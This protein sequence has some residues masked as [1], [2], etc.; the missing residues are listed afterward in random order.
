M[1]LYETTASDLPEL[2]GQ[3]YPST[4]TLMLGQDVLSRRRPGSLYLE[5]CE[6]K[7]HVRAPFAAPKATGCEGV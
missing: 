4:S 7:S 5:L 3:S 2:P 1:L 6:Q